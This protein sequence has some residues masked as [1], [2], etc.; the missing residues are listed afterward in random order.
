MMTRMAASIAALASTSA[1]SLSKAQLASADQMA[2]L[3]TTIAQMQTATAS[4]VGERGG[5]RQQKTDSN[6]FIFAAIGAF[7]G[8]AGFI[9]GA[10]LLAERLV[11]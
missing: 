8:L 10:I 6:A 9:F 2:K 11:H 7:V 4:D 3:M 1:D 5:V